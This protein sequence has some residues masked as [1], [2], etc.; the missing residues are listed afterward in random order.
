[1]KRFNHS[2]L[3][4]M[5]LGTLSS[6]HASE[7]PVLN[8]FYIGLGYGMLG[9]TYSEDI[10]GDVYTLQSDNDYS[11]A[12]LKTGYKINPY[13]AFEGRY[14]LG[15]SDESWEDTIYDNGLSSSIDTWGLY[16]KL[17]APLGDTFNLYALL[18]YA[19]ATYKIEGGDIK[20][21][22]DLFDGFS[23]GVGMDARVTDNMTLFVDYVALYD[24]YETNYRDN[25]TN[26][27]VD[28]LNFG[29]SYTFDAL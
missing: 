5:A 14:W 7:I 18:G 17:F 21:G 1:M 11:Q 4:L 29:F 3:A 24:S 6:T 13:F 8:E 16:G 27:R 26:M 12:M 22:T 25:D 10:D 9:A 19:E 20:A 15:M 23:W 2:L 28:S